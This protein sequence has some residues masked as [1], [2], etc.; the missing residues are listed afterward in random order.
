MS[1]GQLQKEY[2]RYCHLKP[3]HLKRMAEVLKVR[4]AIAHNFYRRRM[5]RLESAEGREQVIRELHEAIYLFQTERDEM[6]WLLSALTGQP[7]R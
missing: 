3:H 2:A 4:N 7:L 6:Y 5:A 1:L